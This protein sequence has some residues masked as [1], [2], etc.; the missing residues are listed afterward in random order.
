MDGL[1]SPSGKRDS[2]EDVK[3]YLSLFQSHES[4]C[5]VRSFVKNDE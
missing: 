3:K 4:T 2:V 1:I 5:F